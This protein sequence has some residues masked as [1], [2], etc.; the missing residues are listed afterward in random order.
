[1]P[2]H[3]SIW[4]SFL[5]ILF[6]RVSGFA[7]A[8]LIDI[9]LDTTPTPQFT[10]YVLVLCQL[11]DEIQSVYFEFDQFESLR[12]AVKLLPQVEES[13]GVTVR[14]DDLNSCATA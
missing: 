12:C 3:I 5:H 6:E 2:L 4:C 9:S 7:D 8:L 13:I 10:I 14:G 11:G 1:M